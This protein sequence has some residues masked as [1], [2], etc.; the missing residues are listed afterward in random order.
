MG[1]GCKKKVKTTTQPKTQVKT[2]TSKTQ[3]PP[4]K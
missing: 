4:K 1:C 2:D 3:N